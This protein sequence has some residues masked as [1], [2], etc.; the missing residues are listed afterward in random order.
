MSLNK[1]NILFCALKKMAYEPDFSIIENCN[2]IRQ[3]KLKLEIIEDQIAKD[4]SLEK[5][6]LYSEFID[7]N[8]LKFL[9]WNPIKKI[10]DGAFGSALLMEDG[11]ILKLTKD[12]T[13]TSMKNDLAEGMF[14]NSLLNSGVGQPMIYESGTLD[15]PQDI[16]KLRFDQDTYLEVGYSI[17]ER[18]NTN[19]YNK[20]T[21]KFEYI[22]DPSG[23]NLQ[24]LLDQVNFDIKHVIYDYKNDNHLKGISLSN[25][26]IKDF[27][28]LIDKALKKTEQLEIVKQVKE[29]Y[30]L[31]EDFLYQLIKTM[32][33][34]EISL[35]FDMHSGNV[36]VRN[37]LLVFFDF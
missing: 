33:Q 36:G 22:D 34:N 37:G 23:S 19:I 15:L 7:L 9:E 3:L 5:R 24:I 29:Q 35:R 8:S 4:E 10:G 32:I 27:N 13:E 12:L 31:R 18:L 17:S 21:N 16:P 11:R 20:S 2:A 14:S 26:P 1:I 30:D 28:I 6:D 25:I